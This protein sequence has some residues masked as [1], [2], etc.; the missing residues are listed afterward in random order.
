MKLGDNIVVVEI[1][2]DG[3]DSEENRAKYN[4]ARQHFEDLNT[5]LK[6]LDVKQKYYFHFLSPA[7]Y[8]EFTQY[9]ADG[10]LFAGKFKSEL[11]YL[12]EKED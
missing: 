3:E 12:L 6:A 4:C 7:S 2:S 5:E 10:R 1:K 8:P 11:E 9:L